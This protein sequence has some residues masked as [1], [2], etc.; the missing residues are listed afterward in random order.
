MVCVMVP[1]KWD[2]VARVEAH[3][4]AIKMPWSLRASLNQIRGSLPLKTPLRVPSMYV[5]M[6]V[7]MY[8]Y[9]CICMY[10][11]MYMYMYVCG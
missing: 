6:Y 7:C 4:S 9:V 3:V 10:V 11:Y 2:I 8:V 1:L 5:C